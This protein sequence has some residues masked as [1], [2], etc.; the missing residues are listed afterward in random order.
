M[1]RP[2]PRR[3]LAREKGVLASFLA[4]RKL[5]KSK[6]RDAILSAFL[7]ME[8]HVT[9]EELH[10][11]LSAEHPGIGLATVYRNLKLLASCGLA[12]Q[13][14]LGGKAARFEHAFRHRHHD[15]LVCSRC[16]KVVEFLD[17][18]IERRQESIASR[19]DFTLESHTLEIHGLC[20]SCRP[21]R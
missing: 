9:A 11:V 21:P 13:V 10:R 6:R 7:A 16:G 5:K 15:H 4:E 17:S 20:G 14:S 19:H 1:T 3:D 8:T 12:K 2:A 18:E